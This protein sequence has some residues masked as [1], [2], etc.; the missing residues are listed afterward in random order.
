MLSCKETFHLDRLSQVVRE[1]KVDDD[2]YK[3]LFYQLT[4]HPATIKFS[5]EVNQQ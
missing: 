5:Q 2:C 1:M 3:A 4:L